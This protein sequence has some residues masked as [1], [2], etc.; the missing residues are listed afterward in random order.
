MF[1]TIKIKQ[2]GNMYRWLSDVDLMF[3]VF[4]F[5]HVLH[6]SYLCIHILFVVTELIVVLDKNGS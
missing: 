1:C 5:T 3:C 6:R 2:D 4:V